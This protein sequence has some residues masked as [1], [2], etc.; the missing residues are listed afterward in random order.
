M[1]RYQ[2]WS[3]EGIKWTEWFEYDS[4]YKPEWQIKNKLL[5]QY[6]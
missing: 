2:Y 3:K 6:K 4:D 5:N 1:K